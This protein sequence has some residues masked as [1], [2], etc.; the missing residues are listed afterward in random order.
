MKSFGV[1][2]RGKL[3]AAS[4]GSREIMI[5]SLVVKESAGWRW[6]KGGRGK[7]RR[8]SIQRLK[9]DKDLMAARDC[10]IRACSC[11]WWDWCIGS[12]P[13]FWRWPKENWVTIRDGRPNFVREGLPSSS[14][15]QTPTAKEFV[16]RVK[17]KLK[18]VREKGYLSC[19]QG[20]KSLTHFFP[21]AKTWK[22]EDGV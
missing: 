17:K 20:V 9:F 11:T 22:Q 21:V 10:I 16:S 4:R 6:K 3:K 5:G 18:V 8:E 12:R 13:F 1:W 2:L 19:D 15:P 7:Y 14:V